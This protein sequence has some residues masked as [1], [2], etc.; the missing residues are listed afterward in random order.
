MK[1]PD[2]HPVHKRAEPTTNAEPDKHDR[3]CLR[4]WIYNGYS[5]PSNGTSKPDPH[6]S[7]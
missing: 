3:F 2:L 1:N 6:C 7:I 4:C 5:C